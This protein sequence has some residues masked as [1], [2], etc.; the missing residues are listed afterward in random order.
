MRVIQVVPAISNESSGPS[1]SVP[2]LCNGLTMAGC[3]VSLHITG[4]IPPQL[5]QVSYK[6]Y[7]YSRQDIGVKNLGRSP[8]MCT[9]LMND[10]YTADIIH[11]NSL[12]RTFIRHGY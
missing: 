4:D 5:K 8:G 12:C 7:N 9:G 3:E 10:A 11:N 2:G 6:V 1:Y